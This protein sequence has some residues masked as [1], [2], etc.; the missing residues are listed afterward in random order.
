M[1]AAVHGSAMMHR[2][3]LVNLEDPSKFA[4]AHLA[5]QNYIPGLGSS[6]LNAELVGRTVRVDFDFL[7]VEIQ[8][9]LIP[10]ERDFLHGLNFGIY[11]GSAAVRIDP[12]Q[13]STIRKL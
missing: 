10:S 9:D 8:V 1:D 5:L 4:A 7:R 13:L 6:G 11:R 12:G 3:L 2:T